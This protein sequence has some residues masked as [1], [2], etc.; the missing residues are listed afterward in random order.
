MHQGRAD[1]AQADVVGDERVA[2]ADDSQQAARDR[3]R[4]VQRQAEADEGQRKQR[5]DQQQ[6]LVRTGQRHD[7]AGGRVL[8]DH[9]SASDNAASALLRGRPRCCRGS[10][11]SHDVSTKGAVSA[12]MPSGAKATFIAACTMTVNTVP[13]AAYSAD[14]RAGRVEHRAQGDGGEHRAETEQAGADQIAL[15]AQQVRGGH[16]QHARRHGEHRRRH[17]AHRQ[18][19]HEQQRRH[20]VWPSGRPARCCCRRR[21]RRPPCRAGSTRPDPAAPPRRH[22]GG[23]PP[24]TPAKA[25]AASSSAQVTMTKGKVSA[26]SCQ[27]RIRL[28]VAE[29]GHH[30]HGP[31]QHHIAP[32]QR[33][34]L[35]E[36]SAAPGRRARR[37]SRT[38]R[39]PAPAGRRAA[40]SP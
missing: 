7:R 9:R 28:A 38:A 32:Q 11:N 25:K 23:A 8:V 15:R 22:K 2:R 12:G 33:R 17:R 29:H 16:R 3:L 40:T 10:R 18:P 37:C 31:A 19:G 4:R 35:R 14:A 24:P 20:D 36:R 13:S 30:R 6:A 1:A 21:Q 39:R 26:D 5:H 34:R 27:V